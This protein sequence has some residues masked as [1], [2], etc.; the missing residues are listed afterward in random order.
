M[1]CH[2]YSRGLAVISALS[3]LENGSPLQS[4]VSWYGQR[5][6]WGGGGGGILVYKCD[7]YILHACLGL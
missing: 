7:Y 1:F 6:I 2:V 4:L 5:E 3:S